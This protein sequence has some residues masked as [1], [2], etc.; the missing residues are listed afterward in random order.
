MKEYKQNMD[1]KDAVFESRKNS[2]VAASQQQAAETVGEPVGADTSSSQTPSDALNDEL[3]MI[4]MLNSRASKKALK[5][6]MM[7]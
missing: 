2:I 6:L 1:D 3:L 4:Q 7:E 5:M